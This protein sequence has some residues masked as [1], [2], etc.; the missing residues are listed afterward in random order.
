MK[1]PNLIFFLLLATTVQPA[2]AVQEN[3]KGLL[4]EIN[5]SESSEDVNQKKSFDSEVMIT[6][7]ENRAIESLNK[8][9]QKRTGKPDE[10]DLLFRLAELY[11]RRAKS[12]R[13]FDLDKVSVN[14]LKQLGLNNQRAN[15]G[16]KQAVEIYNKM[17]RKFP[18]YPDLDYV[19]FNNALANI[20]LKEVEL[21]KKNY[22][23][24]ISAFPKSELIPDTLL[25]VGEIYYNQQNFSA[26]LE[27]F[28]AIEKFPESKAYPYGLYKSAWA[29]YNMRET[30]QAI[31]Q[32]LLVVKQNPADSPDPKK[33]NLR[34]ESLRDLSVFVGER[35]AP[36]KIFGFFEKITSE[37]ELGEIIYALAGLYESHSRFKEISV[38][39]SQ[40]IN[41][42]PKSKQTPKLY[43]KL[44]DTLETLKQR[45]QVLKKLSDM[46]DFCKSEKTELTC[47]EEFRKVSLE[48]SKK[49]WDIWLKNKSNQEF[50]ALTEKAFVNL[51]SLDSV[52]EPDS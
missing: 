37:E 11:M 47:K 15:D 50:S 33:F 23:Q 22:L 20:Q 41:S 30:D 31:Q 48:I 2:L 8:V 29:L 38:F 6:K 3:V 39:A 12:G 9:I 28:K 18:H 42:Y 32:L 5:L 17:L 43:S 49:W 51:L 16:L 26:A 13:Y 52:T 10:P 35:L 36:D 7:T 14:R 21:A 4:S 1:K 34:K 44:I 24:L 45:D 40:Y 25:E 19:F 27:K 46:G